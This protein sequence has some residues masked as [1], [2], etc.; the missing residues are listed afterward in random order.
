MKAFAR[1]LF[2]SLMLSLAGPALAQPAENE[3]FT[4][5]QKSAIEQMIR[6][7]L[8]AN[9]EI[10]IEMTETLERKQKAQ[11]D[12]AAAAGIVEHRGQ[13]LANGYDYIM[14]PAGAVPV[15]EFFDYNCGY[16]K[17]MLPTIRQLQAENDD[18]RFI[19]KE[20]PIL[21]DES[22]QA[23]RVAIAAKKQGKYMELHNELMA[24][25]GRVDG[26][27]AMKVAED[28]GLDMDKL[29][30]DLH[31]PEV[32]AEIDANRRLA[33]ALGIRGTPT[34]LIGESLIP[35]ALPYERIMAVVEERR[36]SCAIC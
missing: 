33:E 34:L 20:F 3:I 10:L 2:L 36:Q 30:Q 28:M 4:P 14:N 23:A 15:V 18:L 9:P 21:S 11:A 12:A 24:Y 1:W 29:K 13:V 17:R 25:R 5:T 22:I 32:G 26:R 19:F 6:E 31:S 35:G 27:V 8:L 7:Y 16:C